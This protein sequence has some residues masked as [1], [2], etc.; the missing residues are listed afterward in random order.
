MTRVRTWTGAD[1][2]ALVR[3]FDA[4]Q[5][6][7]RRELAWDTRDLWPAVERGR[8]AGRVP[9]FVAL[10]ESGALSGWTYF[11][12]RDGDLQIGALSASAPE[13]T[14]ALLDA[15][16]ASPEAATARRA[17]LFA[18]TDAPDLDAALAARGFA[19]DGYAYLERPLAPRRGLRPT[20][21]SWDLR[22]LEAT[23]DLLQASY[24]AV[25]PL[26]PFAPGGQ[27]AAW[28]QYVGDL[29]MG[30]GCG[31][32]RPSLSVAV[33]GDDG[34]LDAVALVTDIGERSA[35]LAQLAVRPGL[36]GAGLGAHL[37]AAVETQAAA[38]GFQRLTLLVSGGNQRAAG[39]YARA[40]F[41]S[42]ARF[43]CA[44]RPVEGHLRR[45]AR[46]GVAA[47]GG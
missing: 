1:T 41:V 42:R 17:L 26:R 14:A 46:P 21:R 6:R 16:L 8:Q 36:R 28:R 39:M 27:P 15:V 30:Q 11:V 20:G 22:D 31:R 37:V 7:W 47:T 45:E 32:F 34:Q 10:G 5:T 13:A 35:H 44:A 25:D 3:A 9:G 23:A 40:G 2:A 33:P 18:F 4:E 38:A 19:A 24:A 43:A 12:C 29:V